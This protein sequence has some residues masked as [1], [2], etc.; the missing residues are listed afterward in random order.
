MKELPFSF[1][2]PL[3]E[4]VIVQR[5]SQFIMKVI[6]DGLEQNCHCPTTNRIADINVSGLSCLISISNDKK[7]KTPYTVEAFSLDT[8][9]N[10][11]KQ[12]IGINQNA[13]NRYVEHFLITGQ[14]H[15]MKLDISSIKREKFL[16]E[17]KIDFLLGSIYLEVKTPFTRIQLDIPDYVKRTKMS[18]FNSFDRFLRH[19]SE[20]TAKLKSGERAIL[21]NCF[22]YDNPGFKVPSLM[23]H[24][25]KMTDEIRRCVDRGLE[26]WQVSLKITP[27]AVTLIRCFELTPSFLNGTMFY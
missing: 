6:I 17:S 5:K 23:S 11:D 4:G 15:M 8:L 16:G 14:L 7:R 10:N 19:I 21:L 26:L 22:I 9:E 20:M 18:E 24:T 1:E 12:W 27:C 13:A 3:K 25:K 2:T